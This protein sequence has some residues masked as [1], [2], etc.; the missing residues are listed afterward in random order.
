MNKGAPIMAVIT[1]A[2]ISPCCGRIL[3]NRSQKT[4]YDP[5]PRIHAGT[6]I[7]WSGPRISRKRCGITS[8]T[9]PSRPQLLTVELTIKDVVTS[10]IVVTLL[11]FTPM[12]WAISFPIRRRFIVCEYRKRIIKQGISVRES[13][14]TWSRSLMER[15]PMSQKMILWSLESCVIDIRNIIIAEQKAFT[16]TPDRS[17][18]S[19]FR[20]DCPDDMTR[21]KR[22]VAMLPR[23]AVKVTPGK[24][25][26]P[27]SIPRMAP[28][29]D[30]PEIPRMYGSASGFLRSA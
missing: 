17:R 28:I 24:R 22:S 19:F 12:V 25:E 4:I 15:S 2:G 3:D 16:I 30:P 7:R 8:P 18:E 29:A 13:I 1:P 21:I 27:A 23:K 10:R 5:P 9:K 11:I 14:P 6:R 26:N 20:I